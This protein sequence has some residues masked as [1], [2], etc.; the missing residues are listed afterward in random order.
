MPTDEDAAR[1]RADELPTPDE[2]T[3]W[4]V[5]F[6]D[7]DDREMRAPEI[8]QALRRGEIRGD[9]IVWREGLPEWVTINSVP[10]LA[11]LLVTSGETRAAP[12][13]IGKIPLV[14]REER[15]KTAEAPV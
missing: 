14:Q 3:L 12:A 5:S 6:G 1:S 7:D 11:R 8:A 2:S 9:T 13:V 15:A 10:L 4:L